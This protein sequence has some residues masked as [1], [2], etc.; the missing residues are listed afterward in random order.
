M[1]Q[2]ASAGQTCPLSLLSSAPEKLSFA[3]MTWMNQAEV[4][5]SLEM[6]SE[7]NRS[8]EGLWKIRYQQT[9]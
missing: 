4:T 6:K 8:L 3:L 9:R 7:L 1:G 5:F 2:S